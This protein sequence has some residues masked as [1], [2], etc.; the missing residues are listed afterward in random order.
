MYI[1]KLFKEC[2][3]F[4]YLVK[5]YGQAAEGEKLHPSF[6]YLNQHPNHH[7]S[8]HLDQTAAADDHLTSN[9]NFTRLFEQVGG[10]GLQFFFGVIVN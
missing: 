10:V 5:A 2:I 3:L 7:L 8:D 9:K 1:N 4:R 6:S